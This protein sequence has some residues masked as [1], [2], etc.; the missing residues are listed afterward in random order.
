MTATSASAMPRVHAGLSA[1]RSGWLRGAAPG[2][3]ALARGARG[4]GRGREASPDIASP[5]ASR[6]TPP[7]VDYRATAPSVY[8]GIMANAPVAQL[9]VAISSRALFDF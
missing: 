6:W 5:A 9:V 1:G 4:I 7:D 3:A 8:C 2:S